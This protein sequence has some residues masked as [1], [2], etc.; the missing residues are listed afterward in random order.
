MGNDPACIATSGV[1]PAE[2]TKDVAVILDSIPD[3]VYGV[4]LAGRITLVN[5]SAALMLG[6]DPHELVGRDPHELFHH[7]RTDGSPYPADECPLARASAAG[8]AFRSDAE[9]F[10]RRDGTG[11]PIQCEGQ[12]L[13]RNG[14]IVGFVC[15]FRDITERLQAEERGRQLVR[16]QFARARIELQYSE[17]RDVLAQTPA[18]ICVTRGPRHVVETIN[19]AYRQFIGG[20]AVS[21]LA[22]L[23]AF[24]DADPHHVA[25]M[26]RVFETGEAYTGTEVPLGVTGVADPSERLF[27]LVYQP[28]R[29]ETGIVSGVMMH[30]VDVTEQVSVRRALEERTAEL[31]RVAAALERS[32]R[33]LDAFAYAASHDLRAPLRGIANLAQWIEEDLPDSM[34]DETKEMLQLM[35]SRMHRMEALIEGILHYSRAGRD[36]A[37][38]ERVDSRQLLQ[39]VTDLLAPPPG[40][41]V[42]VPVEMP[43]LLTK[44]MPLQQVFM[45]LIGNALKYAGRDHAV[46]E[47]DVRDAGAFYEFSVSD[48]GPGIAPEYQDRIWGIFQTLEARDKVEATG[49]GLALVKKL[50]EAQ[51]G[52]VWVESA[53]DQGATFRFLWTKEP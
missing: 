2:L 50:V 5:E 8:R 24:P 25:R 33:E 27:N 26:D 32:N 34:K 49:I 14:S 45:N 28:L 52:R 12:P 7:S 43:T 9:M 42:T 20:R 38:P 51:G 40:A 4:D 18:V 44:R 1:F 47:I 22:F 31:G 48:N 35:R 16:E 53:P 6:Y 36:H 3:G 11:F 10:W 29:D 15:T 46:V 17:L 30:A 13:L 37:D 41:V 39:E 21:G 23:E 19:E